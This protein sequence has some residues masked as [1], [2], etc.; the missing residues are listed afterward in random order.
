MEKLLNIVKNMPPIINTNLYS[1][2]KFM[3]GVNKIFGNP[4]FISIINSLKELKAIK[5]KNL[6]P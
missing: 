6:E 2:I 5:N 1:Q 3:E 4:M